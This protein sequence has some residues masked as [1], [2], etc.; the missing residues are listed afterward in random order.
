MSIGWERLKSGRIVD[1]QPGP[2]RDQVNT[3]S[4]E[5]KHPYVP[6]MK[7]SSDMTPEQKEMV[8]NWNSMRKML[9][10]FDQMKTKPGGA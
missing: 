2:V 6:P 1:A 9:L 8:K 7:M 3:I 4:E 5:D 10:E